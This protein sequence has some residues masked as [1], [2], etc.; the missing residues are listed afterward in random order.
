LPS[1]WIRIS[2]DLALIIIN[3]YIIFSLNI[4]QFFDDF[5]IAH[6]NLFFYFESIGLILISI[7][8]LL[9]F[10]TAYSEK[11]DIIKDKQKIAYRYLT[12]T[13]FF[14][15]Y[16][17]IFLIID[18]LELDFYFK[19]TQFFYF[20]HSLFYLKIFSLILYF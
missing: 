15:L 14:D 4:Y 6:N 2:L 19:N 17:L 20:Y 11:G 10:F 5:D 9:N 13:F 12:H 16:S 1:S 8:I 3:C 7:D 18:N